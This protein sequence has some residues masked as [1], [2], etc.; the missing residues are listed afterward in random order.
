M[1][2]LYLSQIV[3][4]TVINSQEW[5]RRLPPRIPAGLKPFYLSLTNDAVGEH[6]FENGHPAQRPEKERVVFA[7]VIRLPREAQDPQMC[8][9]GSLGLGHKYPCWPYHSTVH[10]TPVERSYLGV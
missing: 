8:A 1:N 5:L 7:G 9:V 4:L 2:V 10:A 6:L 3:L